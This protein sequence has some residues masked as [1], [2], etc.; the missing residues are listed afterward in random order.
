MIMKH[1][2]MPTKKTN[3]IL[4]PGREVEHLCSNRNTN[5]SVHSLDKKT[6]ILCVQ[7][8]IF[9]WHRVELRKD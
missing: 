8:S 7:T 6:I 1:E 9:K 2:G 3:Q 5:I 4:K